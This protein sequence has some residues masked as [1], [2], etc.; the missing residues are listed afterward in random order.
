MRLL[1]EYIHGLQVRRAG[2]TGD[3]CHVSC[4]VSRKEMPKARLR[5]ESSLPPALPPSSLS[6]SL[7]LRVPAGERPPLPS[8]TLGH[9]PIYSVHASV[10]GLAAQA[11]ASGQQR[12]TVSVQPVSQGTIKPARST[13]CVRFGAAFGGTVLAELE[14]HGGEHPSAARKAEVLACLGDDPC[15]AAR[16]SKRTVDPGHDCTQCTADEIAEATVTALRRAW[17]R[18][19]RCRLAVRRPGAAVLLPRCFA[20]CAGPLPPLPRATRDRT[21]GLNASCC[22]GPRLSTCLPCL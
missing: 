10:H 12:A 20:V 16:P 13:R 5:E 17:C 4:R 14:T 22:V 15:A 1:T 11:S 2:A 18:H 8:Q 7:S 6:L 21:H 19:T 9:I 3:F